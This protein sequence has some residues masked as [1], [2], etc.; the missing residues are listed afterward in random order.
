MSGVMD[1]R[2]ANWIASGDTGTSSKAIM[3]WFSAGVVDGTWGASTPSDP[4]DLGRCLRLLERFPEWKPRMAEMAGAG[5]LW[6]TFSKRWSEIEACFIAEC[7]GELPGRNDCGWSC[8]KTYDLMKRVHK[9]AY[10][11][12][13]PAWQEVSFRDRMSV[14]FPS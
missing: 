2:L 11:A 8:P 12:D 6:P 13:K 14:R 4:A 3:L 1:P 9:Q 5:G 7:G 10:E